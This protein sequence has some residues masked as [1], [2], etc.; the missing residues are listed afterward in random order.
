MH[1][2]IRA[3]APVA[4]ECAAMA[5]VATERGF[6]AA[7]RA[8]VERKERSPNSAANTREKI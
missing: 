4:V 7:P 6:C 2:H 8:M 5:P 1:T 3:H